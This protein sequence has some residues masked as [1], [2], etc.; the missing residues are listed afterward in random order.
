MIESVLAVK[1]AFDLL[2]AKANADTLTKKADSLC[3]KMKADAS[4]QHVALSG[5]KAALQMDGSK[6]Q[7]MEGCAD[8]RSNAFILAMEQYTVSWHPNAYPL[9][10]F[11]G[12][13]KAQTHRCFI[14]V[15]S[16]VE[17]RKVGM[18]AISALL[19]FLSTDK[20]AME[21]IQATCAFTCILEPKGAPLYL[22]HGN[23]PVQIGLPS[24]KEDGT[25]ST[26]LFVPTYSV[27]PTDMSGETKILMKQWLDHSYRTNVGFKTWA[28]VKAC[29]EP[30]TDKW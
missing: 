19:S 1:T 3:A 15:F 9:P 25:K 16:I 22:P 13:L 28:A 20:G 27:M 2:A 4:M 18:D 6:Y 17:L 10:G 12:F 8:L 21:A 5:D 7:P 29:L 23:V 11:E 26:V 30:I 14:A 24:E